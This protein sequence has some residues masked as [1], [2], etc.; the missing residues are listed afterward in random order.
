MKE[1]ICKIKWAYYDANKK[2]VAVCVAT[3]L[4]KAIRYFEAAELDVCD[5][6]GV[7]MLEVILE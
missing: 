6:S 7:S 4:Y 2:L 3:T 5:T 1:G